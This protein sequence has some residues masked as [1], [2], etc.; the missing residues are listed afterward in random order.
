MNVGEFG[1]SN[2]HLLARV[3]GTLFFINPPLRSGSARFCS[4]IRIGPS[5]FYLPGVPGYRHV[6]FW[7]TQEDGAHPR[8]DWF[9][10]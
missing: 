7:L 2:K 4:A 8:P 5:T 3:F 6:I 9:L 10:R 1:E